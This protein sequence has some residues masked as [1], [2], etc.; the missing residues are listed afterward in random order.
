M[1]QHYVFCR[2]IFNMWIILLCVCVSDT[3]GIFLQFFFLVKKPCVFIF[4]NSP[5]TISVPYFFLV[6]FV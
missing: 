2:L 5:T 4:P 3:A 6:T 1:T